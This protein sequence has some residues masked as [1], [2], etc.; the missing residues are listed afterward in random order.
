MT[1]SPAPEAGGIALRRTRE[2]TID[3]HDFREAMSRLGSA[4]HIATTDGPA[5]RSG[6][7]VS[8]VTSVSDAPPTVLVCVN[9]QARI[10]AAIKSNGLFAINTLPA[11]AEPLSDAF[12]GKGELSFD[13]RFALAD[14]TRLVTGAPILGG[15]RVALDCRVTEVS[16]IGTHSVIFGEIVGIRLG[17]RGPALIYLDRTYH[18]I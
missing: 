5:G 9:R 12:A 17:E 3:R 16:E 11:H 14:W 13:E 6:T 8:A 2:S 10:N 18:R 15:A 4:V 1:S 7:T